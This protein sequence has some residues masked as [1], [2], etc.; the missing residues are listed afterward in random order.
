MF[1]SQVG[2]GIVPATRHAPAAQ[3]QPSAGNARRSLPW[4]RRSGEAPQRAPGPPSGAQNPLKPQLFSSAEYSRHRTEKSRP[5]CWTSRVGFAKRRR[6]RKGPSRNGCGRIAQLVEQLTLNQRV[7]GSSPSAPTK[8]TLKTRHSNQRVGLGG[9]RRNLQCEPV[10]QSL[11]MLSEYGLTRV[12]DMLAS[13]GLVRFTWPSWWP[14]DRLISPQAHRPHCEAL[15]SHQ[16]PNG[17]IQSE[18]FAVGCCDRPRAIL[19]V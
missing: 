16:K 10:S 19:R 14:W 5:H 7:L 17:S 1:S 11:S 12:A 15:N 18:A 3:R 13:V 4:H 2:D 8:P 6:P 9:V